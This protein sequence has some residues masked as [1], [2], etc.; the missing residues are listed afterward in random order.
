MSELLIILFGTAILISLLGW[1]TER[2]LKT[3]Y[4]KRCESQEHLFGQITHSIKS[5]YDYLTEEVE[6]NEQTKSTFK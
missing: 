2:L 4:K 1:W 5:L 3:W 6:E